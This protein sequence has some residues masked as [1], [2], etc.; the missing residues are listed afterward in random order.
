MFH[1]EQSNHLYILSDGMD[2]ENWMECLK[3]E[4]CDRKLS[5]IVIPGTHDSGSYCITRKSKYVFEQFYSHI[6]TC[7]ILTNQL[8]TN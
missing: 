6:F 3:D 1:K 5:E 7:H 8:I 4:L 2:L